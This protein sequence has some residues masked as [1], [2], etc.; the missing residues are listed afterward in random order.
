MS[1]ARMLAV[2]FDLGYTLMSFHPPVEELTLQALREIGLPVGREQVL[3]ALGRLWK[4]YE[5]EGTQDPFPATPEYDAAREMEMERH[6]LAFLGYEDEKIRR[7]YHER[8]EALFTQPGVMR[9]YDDVLPALE[10]LKARGY[11]LGIISNWSWNLVDR[12]RHLG[13]DSYFD[14]IVASAYVGYNKP[15]PAIFQHALAQV[16]VPPA[17]A[18]HV[19]DQYEADVLGAQAAGMTG[20][21]LDRKGN[22]PPAS[23][24]VIHS[25]EELLD[26]LK[27][28][29]AGH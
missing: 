21:L 23:C 19:G 11:R 27:E 10:Q 24:P 20:I 29:E 22:A 13:I 2:F 28:R 5:R 3:P 7:R 6:F 15:H 26:W 1:P 9:L 17:A 18:V 12:C 8:L 14:A 16:G 25:L 4:A